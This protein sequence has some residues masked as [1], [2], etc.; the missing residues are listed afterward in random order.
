M[1]NEVLSE[2]WLEWITD[3]LLNGADEASLVGEL[4]RQ[5]VAK[6]LAREMLVAIQA[7]PVYR[8]ARKHSVKG[9]RLELL[10]RL[11]VAQR[12][13][14][15]CPP[16]AERIKL[17]PEPL[18]LG[19][20]LSTHTPV[21]FTDLVARWPGKDN[22]TP[23]RLKERFGDVILDVA[24][25]R[26]TEVNYDRK[27]AQ[28]SRKMPLG[29][30]VEALQSVES[31]ND[32][33]AVAQNK[34]LSLPELHALFQD[35]WFPE[36][37]LDRADLGR[38]SALWLGPKGTITSLH[39]D[40]SNILFSQLYGRK[41]FL[42]VNP[43]ELELAEGATAMY[44]A[45]DPE[46]PEGEGWLQGKLVKRVVLEPGET[47]LIPAGWWH[48]VRALEVSVSVAVNSLRLPNNFDWYRPGEVT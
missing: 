40:T 38:G 7:S 41:Q 4:E 19:N 1:E 10:R 30:F 16:E 36:S 11:L 22:F 6:E 5:G 45:L 23:E 25:G 20:W 47:L 44:A 28:L 21:I 24:W 34:N 3:N 39:H 29:K 48:H 37:W 43:L 32:F 15:Q 14:E 27:T 17:G 35:M 13:F 31:T 33:Y 46:S 26:Q 12:W 2:L 18:G 8:A 42:L 9:R